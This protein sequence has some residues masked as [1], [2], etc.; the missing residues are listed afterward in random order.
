MRDRQLSDVLDECLTLLTEDHLSVEACLA[1]YPQHAAELRPILQIALEMR[2][3]PQPE[4]SRAAFRAGKRRMLEAVRQREQERQASCSEHNPAGLLAR[5]RGWIASLVDAL[6]PPAPSSSGFGWQAAVATAAVLLIVAIGGGLLLPSWLGTTVART[7]RLDPLQGAVE[8]Q[9]ADSAAWL[10]VSSRQRLQAGDRVR[11][12]AEGVA[13]LTFFDGSTTAL[14]G[15]TELALAELSSRRDGTAKAIVIHQQ[16]GRT[17]NEVQPLRRPSARFQVKTPTAVAHVRGT[18]FDVAVEADGTTQVALWRGMVDVKRVAD[19]ASEDGSVKLQPGWFV[20]VSPDEPISEPVVLPT[21][22]TAKQFPDLPTPLPT[23][24][25]TAS[26]T[27]RP[28]HTPT[29]T[30]YPTRTP[31][32]TDTASPSTR[33][34]VEPPT[35]TPLP[36]TDT[37]APPTDTPL[38]PTATPVPPTD[39][40]EPPPNP[41]SPPDVP[42]ETV[43]PT[44]TPLPPTDTPVP[45]PDPTDPP[46]PPES[47][48]PDETPD[49]N[50]NGG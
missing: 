3:T 40:P 22:G 5:C 6:R 46:Q 16:R 43:E 13:L 47:E 31:A 4:P 48:L 33:E 41:T 50:D 38:P 30:P 14:E 24:T 12:D 8:V 7:A 15:E 32:P 28:T 39:T 17:H 25:A 42:V 36:P 49:P 27:P 19:T 37:P 44:A 2:R 9:A 29:W 45:P 1:R 10:P 18:A 34:D 21:P 26:A 20:S 23:D 11:T 35:A